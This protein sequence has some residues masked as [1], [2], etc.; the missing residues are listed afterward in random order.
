MS[1]TPGPSGSTAG[2]RNRSQT[3]AGHALLRASI[4]TWPMKIGRS[5]SNAALSRVSATVAS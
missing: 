3:P 1:Y 2:N 5:R 4:V